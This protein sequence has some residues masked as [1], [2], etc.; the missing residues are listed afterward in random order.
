MA[1]PTGPPP[2]MKTEVVSIRASASVAMIVRR[3]KASNK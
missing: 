3:L 2:T 1:R